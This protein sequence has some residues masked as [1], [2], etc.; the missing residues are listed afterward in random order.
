MTGFE[1]HERALQR[2][3]RAWDQLLDMRDPIRPESALAWRDAR[4]EV[5]R[6]RRELHVAAEAYWG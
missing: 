4:A 1:R 3:Q 2:W 6:L 5:D